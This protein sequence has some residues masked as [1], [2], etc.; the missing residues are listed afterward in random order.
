MHFNNITPTVEAWK[1]RF[2]EDFGM[3][4]HRTKEGMHPYISNFITRW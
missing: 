4:V 3:L 2:R 1:R